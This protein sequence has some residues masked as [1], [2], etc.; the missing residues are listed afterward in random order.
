MVA[1]DSAQ[2]PVKE[3]RLAATIRDVAHAAGVA[4][5]TVSRA[6]NASTLVSPG[7]RDRV[8][9]AAARLGYQPSRTARS[10]VTGRTG[11][12]GLIVPDL[13]NPFFPGVVKGVQARARGA[14]LSVFIAD[15]D[16][17]QAVEIGLIRELAK[18]ID[19]LLLCSPRSGEDAI[20]ELASGTAIVLVNRRVGDQPAITV[21]NT[22]GMQQAAAHLVALGH[23]RIGFV[24]GPAASW[25][26]GQRL[27]ALRAFANSAGIELVEVGNFPPQFE[28]GVAAADLVIAAQ[29]S[30]VIAYNDVVALGLL[31]RLN[32]R[33][34]NV[35]DQISV[36]GCDDIPTARMSSPALTTVALPK[37]QAGRHAVDLLLELIHEPDP[38]RPMHR[39]LPTQLMVRDSTGP[40]RRQGPSA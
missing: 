23:R 22:A 24:G 14:R 28:G 32:A 9:Q 5:S 16:E 11:N 4:P 37:E 31:S 7:T 10:L 39:E 25:S 26:G 13:S 20:R 38:Q 27:H 33:G 8:Q 2:L 19:G 30:A 29:L 34:V 40:L 6:L 1:N 15:S 21:D 35:P 17:D 36:V 3:G 12:L 18:Q